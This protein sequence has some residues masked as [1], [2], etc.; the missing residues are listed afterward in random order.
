[1]AD[2]QIQSYAEV[3][4]QDVIK[5]I[6]EI[7]NKEFDI[8]ID[9]EGQ[10]DLEDI[11]NFYQKDKGAFWVATIDEVVIG[12]ISLL[13][14]GSNQGALRKMFVGA[15]F[16]GKEYGVGQDLLDTLLEFA[17]QKGYS[18][19]FLG[20]T[21]KFIAAHRFYEKNGFSLLNK[22]DLPSSFPLVKVDTRFYKYKVVGY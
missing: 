22:G 19:L 14:I 2:I 5:L 4:K 12:T 6:L 21:E 20:T 13:D 8:G 10:P 18:D 17:Y 11:P 9:L 16:R 7:Q 1:M 15:G 3:Y